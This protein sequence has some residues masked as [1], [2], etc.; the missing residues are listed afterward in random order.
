MC[1]PQPDL[2]NTRPT[3][4][5]VSPP[6]D[7]FSP[8]CVEASLESPEGAFIWSNLFQMAEHALNAVEPFSS[9]A[10][11]SPNMLETSVTP[12]EAVLSRVDPTPKVVEHPPPPQF[13]CGAATASCLV[14]SWAGPQVVEDG[15]QALQAADASHETRP[16]R[17]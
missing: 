14:Q 10:E 6:L 8:S 1:T 4:I 5:E 3:L 9:L 2:V 15:A 11:P 16:R 12:A 13:V 7:E 17:N